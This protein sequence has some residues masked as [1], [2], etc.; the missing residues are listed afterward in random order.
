MREKRNGNGVDD[1][2]NLI[3]CDEG[4]HLE[5][6][7]SLR[8]DRKTGQSNP[9]LELVVL[10]TIYAFLNAEGGTLLIGL[11]DDIKVIGIDDDY[12]SS[13]VRTGMDS[14]TLSYQE[15]QTASVTI[16][17]STSASRSITCWAKTCVR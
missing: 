8:V 11:T 1:I 7:A 13:K 12:P 9:A 15:Y 10:R 3:Q 4:H 2:I 6:K 14:R 17:S 5:F 16:T